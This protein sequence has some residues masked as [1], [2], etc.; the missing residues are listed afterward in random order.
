MLVGTLGSQ[1]QLALAL[2]LLKEL[3][4][5]SY[6]PDAFTYSQAVKACEKAE[7]WREPLW[8]VDMM[9]SSAVN[10]DEV[11]LGAV[12]STQSSSIKAGVTSS[13]GS[14]LYLASMAKAAIQTNAIMFNSLI[15][16]FGSQW[17]ESVYFMEKMVSNFMQPNAFVCSTLLSC[18]VQ[19][20]K[21]SSA[22]SLWLDVARLISF[23]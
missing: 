5:R 8:I 1:S 20:A 3:P 9:A 4:H 12:L 23:C 19:A 11:T 18:C 15:G 7:S 16:T 10:L 6:R 21:W 14:A 22:L 13:W 17:M 2:K